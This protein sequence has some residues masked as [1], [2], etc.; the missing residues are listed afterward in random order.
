[1]GYTESE[2]MVRVDFFKPSGK[3]YTTEEMKWVDYDR[4]DIYAAFSQSLLLTFGNYFTDM[5]AVCLEPYHVNAHP[6]QIKN[7]GWE[8]YV[9]W[10]KFDDRGGVNDD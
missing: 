9:S 6:V 10:D 2:D 4:D 7:G 8:N 3:W 5:D 1:M